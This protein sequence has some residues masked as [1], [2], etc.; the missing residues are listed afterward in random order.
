MEN[1]YSLL[2]KISFIL[3]LVLLYINIAIKEPK[4]SFI[5]L[6]DVAKK[7][8]AN[9]GEFSIDSSDTKIIKSIRS[10]DTG[11]SFNVLSVE[12]L[13]PTKSLV[14]KSS[15]NRA[16]SV[17]NNGLHSLICAAII[18]FTVHS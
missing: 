17:N 7:Y 10:L 1:N 2:L 4:E 15:N 18:P 12:E 16:I 11:L 13:P 14:V 9:S 5:S 3:L 8:N 6:R